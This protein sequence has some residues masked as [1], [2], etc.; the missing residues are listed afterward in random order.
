MF[1]HR[2]Y[3]CL[4]SPLGPASSDG[5][6]TNPTCGGGFSV[7]QGEGAS[8]FCRP[9]LMGQY[10]TIRSTKSGSVALTLCEVEVYSARRGTYDVL[11]HKCNVSGQKIC[12]LT[13]AAL[14]MISKMKD[15]CKELLTH[16]PQQTL[17]Y[18]W[19]LL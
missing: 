1:L 10:V 18:Y 7:S 3:T 17:K 8:F 13:I 5:G 4:F 15:A 16:L 9:S 19:Q 2:V 6:V 14:K 11:S 12:S